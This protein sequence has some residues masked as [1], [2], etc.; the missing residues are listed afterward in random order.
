VSEGNI[1]AD[2]NKRKSCGRRCR[3]IVDQDVKDRKDIGRK[4][5]N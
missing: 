4:D 1:F 5:P 3:A 2:G